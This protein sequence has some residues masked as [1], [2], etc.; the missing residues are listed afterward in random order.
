MRPASPDP[1]FAACL[2][3]LRRNL[4]F[5][6]LGTLLTMVLVVAA[7][8]DVVPDAEL[9]C[10]AGGNV[11]LSLLRW[12]DTRRFPRLDEPP[13]PAQREAGRR[14]R[15]R[16]LLGVFLS[17]LAWGLPVAYWIA[18]VPLHYQMFFIIA[19]L[20]MGTGAIYAYCIDLP[21]LHSFMLPYFLP[22]MFVLA[23]RPDT[24]LTVMGIAGILYLAVS[25]AFAHRMHRTQLDSLRLRFDNLDLLARLQHEKEAAERSDLA[26]SRFLAAA[27]HDLRQP[28]HALSLFVGVLR[29]QPLPENSRRVVDN[30]SQA[31][32][33]MGGL[34]D[35]LLNLSRLDAGVVRPRV[36]PVALGP[37]LRRL[38]REFAPQAA[39]KSLTLR[40][41]PVSATVL[42]DPALLDRI[43]RNLIDNAIR[44]TG[45][46]GV[47]VGWPRAGA[48]RGGGGG[49]YGP[50]LPGPGPGGVVWEFH[51]LGNPE[52]DRNKGLG[53]GLAIVQRTARL[54][55]HRLQ[56]RSRPG[57]GTV[58]GLTLP[59]TR[60]AV[61]D[62]PGL[63]PPADVPAGAPLVLVV[64][65]DG[66]SRHGLQQLLESWGYRVLAAGSADELLC[67]TGAETERPALVISDYRLREHATGIEA[68]E[69]V[70]EEYNDDGIAALLVSGD[71][72]PGR[73]AEVAARGWPLLHKPVD[74]DKLRAAIGQLT[75]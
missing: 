33:A 59:R 12:R 70:R 48:G 60:A 1:V 3:V 14:W 72:D 8:A 31:V 10:W 68:I 52:R 25:L 18:H 42:S 66:F 47:L 40:L 22:T 49:G 62:A 24:L 43:L 71:T 75:A 64:E 34:F 27:S 28:V 38:Q 15:R 50:R 30:I 26:K 19:L 9:A 57:R 53:L 56:L 6:L 21:L 45:D 51:Q 55:G 23:A 65:D 58:F 41:R 17:G 11:L 5:S 7:L 54:L 36:E 16:M 4:P 44:H 2:L 20:T 35:G 63:P 69:R 74:P 73:L 61:A 37:L 29:E 39:A 67:L 46:G 32:Q 13:S